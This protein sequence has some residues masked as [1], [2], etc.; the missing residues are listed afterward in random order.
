[1]ISPRE[2]SGNKDVGSDGPENRDVSSFIGELM[3]PQVFV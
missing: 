1:M 2:G 3:Y